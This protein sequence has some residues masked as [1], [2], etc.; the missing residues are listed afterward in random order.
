MIV[1]TGAAGFIGSNV[2]AELEEA[3]FG[4]LAAC[5]Y[6]SGNDKSPNIAK[7]R[8]D[9]FI[10]PG[11]LKNWL[12]ENS[13]LQ[14][15]IHLGAIS[16]TLES[17]VALL[18][19]VNIDLTLA[20]WDICASKAIPLIYASSAAVY[21]G[22]ETQLQD[23]E[24]PAAIAR[25][26]PLNSY[27]W[28]KAKTDQIIATRLARGGP[29]PPQWVG[30]R[31]F[32]VYGP[33]EY[34]KGSMMSVVAKYFDLVRTGRP[35]PL[36]RSNKAG[37]AD[38][39]QKRDFI[40]VKDCTETILWFLRNPDVS[41]LFNVGTGNARSF[42]DVIRA[43]GASLGTACQIR[44]VEMP[45]QLIGRYQ[46]CTCADMCKLAERGRDYRNFRS[47][48]DGIRDYVLNYLSNSDPYR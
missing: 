16:S 47:I 39:E 34:H 29:A 45:H 38:G 20:L 44:Y 40:Y 19:E 18:T 21:G 3:E 31:F 2:L 8:V 35:V 9:R 42:N 22:I 10:S 11:D 32:N 24:E 23:T 33:N 46:Y 13:G 48:E 36:F 5:D 15:V 1:V 30:L 41:G 28:S 7:R 37:I 43:M 14:A 25:L 26:K 27:G 12:W 17:N 6:F 4:P